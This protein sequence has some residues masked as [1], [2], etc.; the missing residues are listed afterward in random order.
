MFT[1]ADI[2][3]YFIA[4]KQ[5]GLFF[6]CIG[7]ACVFAAGIFIFFAKKIFYKGMAVP[8]VALGLL[9][10]I[11]G[12]TVYKRSDSDRLKNVYAYGM[13]PSE[14]KEKELP[15]MK[16]VMKNFILY[17]W[18]EI[19]FVLIGSGL[20]YYFRNNS[21]KQFWA[22]VGTGLIIMAVLALFADYFAEKRGRIYTI[23]IESFV[24]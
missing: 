3:N 21:D 1:K 22:G 24:K 7:I 4:E 15:R 18:M 19:A 16:K 20:V 14:L 5:E 11:V 2:E 6:L 12:F 17:R 23:G 13:N 9:L 10:G 8:L